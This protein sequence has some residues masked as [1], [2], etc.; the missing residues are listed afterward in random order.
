V[1]FDDALAVFMTEKDAVKCR[2]FASDRHWY[3]PV[4]AQLP[5]AFCTRLER[6]LGEAPGAPAVSA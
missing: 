4:T 6:L 1:D 5:D 2:G 3:V